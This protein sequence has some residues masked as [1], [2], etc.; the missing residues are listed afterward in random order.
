M[1][2]AIRDTYRQPG[3]RGGVGYY[4]IMLAQ[5]L[6]KIVDTL[7]IYTGEPEAF[8]GCDT[9]QDRTVYRGTGLRRRFKRLK[10]FIHPSSLAMDYSC[11]IFP[12]PIEP[13]VDATNSKRIVI[14]HDLIPLTKLDGTY[15]YYQRYIYF[16][17]FLGHMFRSV[18]KIAAVSE[19]T[20]QDLVRYYRLPESK[21]VVIYNGFNH[22]LSSNNSKGDLGEGTQQN[23]YGDYVLYF[24]NFSPHKNLERLIQAVALT[25]KQ[26]DINLVLVGSS[27][28][29]KC[30]K[31]T[32]RL[33]IQENVFILG[34]V[35]DGR[36][37][38]ILQKAKAFVLPSLYEGFG[39]PPLEAMAAGVPV[40]VSQTSSLPEVCG[41]AA[42]YFN[43]YDI[44][45]IANTIRKLLSDKQVR[46]RCIANGFEQIRLFD[47][48]ITAQNIVKM[49]LSL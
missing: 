6:N 37:S 26:M 42:L 36:L 30:K 14:A 46:Q 12:H 35:S 31:V 8:P 40:A 39:M 4:T 24:G 5:E 15:R 43:P 19:S 3:I 1:K 38:E 49:I 25:R 22:F 2:L 29:A 17:Y 7:H 10:D 47:W 28:S 9:I 33:G 44:L 34:H 18:D 16:K 11:V 27:D 45:D 48:N 21:I 23:H 20:K 13:L 32:K 41:D